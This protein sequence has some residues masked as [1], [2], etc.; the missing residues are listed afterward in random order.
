MYQDAG[1]KMAMRGDEPISR[2]SPTYR[3]LIDVGLEDR[4]KLRH[5]AVDG[6]LARA[7]VGTKPAPGASEFKDKS[8]LDVIRTVLVREGIKPPSDPWIG[9]R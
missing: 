8:L 1:K 3:N 6:L 7:A 9:I 2:T 5:A 4:T